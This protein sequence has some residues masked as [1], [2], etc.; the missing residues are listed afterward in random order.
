MTQAGLDILGKSQHQH[1]LKK[2]KVVVPDDIREVLQKHPPAW[3]NYQK[4]PETYR[5]IRIGWIDASRHRPDTFKQ[6]LNYF[7][8]KTIKNE[9]YGMMEKK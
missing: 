7:L 4:F 9:R 8:K 2:Q 5:R 6:R 3:E 1:R